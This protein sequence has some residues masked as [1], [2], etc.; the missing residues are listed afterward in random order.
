M[1]CSAFFILFGVSMIKSFLPP[2]LTFPEHTRSLG[3][4]SEVRRVF[5]ALFPEHTHSLRSHAALIFNPFRGIPVHYVGLRCY[6]CILFSNEEY[7]SDMAGKTIDM[8]K[9][10]QVLR[11]HT[12]GSSNRCIAK[13]LRLNKSTVNEYIRKAKLDPLGIA[14]LMKLEGPILEGRFFAGSPAYSDTRMATFLDQL[15]YFRDQLEGKNHVTKQILWQEYRASNLE[16]YGKSQ[17]YYHLKQNLVAMKS[18]VTVLSGLY[19]PAEK[20]FVDFAGDTL[21]YIDI[22]TAE[23]VSVQ[24][25]V[26]TMPYSD[27][28]FA[29]CVPSQRLDDFIYAVR[30]CFE[31][32]GGVPSIVV[33]D[34]LKSAVVKADRYEPEINKAFEDMGNHYGFVVIPA[35]SGKPKDKALV[36]NQVKQVYHRVYAK[37]RNRQFYSILELNEAVQELVTNHN[38]TR[39]QQRPYT[40]EERFFAQERELLGELPSSIYEVKN[41]A[42]ITVQ[43]TGLVYISKDKHYYSVPYQFVGRK[44]KVIFTRSVVKV[45]VDHRCVAT[46][47]RSR[48]YGHTILK[49]HL[50]PNSL[51]YVDRS[52]EYFCNKAA[53]ISLPLERLIRSLFMNRC[54]GVTN[55]IYY[56]VC[57]KMLKLQRTT[58]K[59]VFEKSCDICCDN[60]LYRADSL[61]NV[62]VTITKTIDSEPVESLEIT[63]SENTRGQDYYL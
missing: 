50:S 30:M 37:L 10:A 42:E 52:P 34:N 25:F 23:K 55:E 51:A 7:S 26:A 54:S 61:Q 6:L 43:P 13:A 19:K 16:G 58:P 22:A 4:Y 12:N 8:S 60:G 41:Y 15:S 46:H 5:R 56:R 18:P 11:M 49:E 45:Y 39:M 14:A 53:K 33:P 27:Y 48:E 28:A 57:E 59:E 62:I 1:D 47:L 29:I 17:F 20:M 38:Q 3:L 35:R 63:N 31:N 32:L 9:I 21:S 36:E 24:V 40:R 44:A 2:H